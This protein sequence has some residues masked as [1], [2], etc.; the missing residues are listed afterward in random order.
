M[1]IG[2]FKANYL[3]EVQA[4]DI[5]YLLGSYAADQMGGGNPIA[6]DILN[7]VVVELSRLPHA[8]SVLAYVDEKPAGLINCFETFST[9]KCKPLVNI[10]DVVVLEAYRRLGLAQKMLS[11]V[12]EIARQKGCCKL[13]LEV[14]EGNQ[15]AQ[16]AY[17]KYGFSGYELDPK[18]GKALFWE[19][20]IKQN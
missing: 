20:P 11:K 14:L 13:T 17:L 16:Q 6:E 3:D 1:E 7:N 12:E 9:F 2:L 10:H 18:M 8:F 19:K 5:K 4:K 15:A